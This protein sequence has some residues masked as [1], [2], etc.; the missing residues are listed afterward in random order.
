M[1][2]A[3]AREGGLPAS[4]TFAEVH[5]ALEMPLNALYLT[6]SI[7]VMFGFVFL[8]STTAFNAIAVASFVALALS[9][10]MPL[11]VHCAQGRNK[12]PK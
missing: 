8:I 12:L 2:Y 6:T 1:V 4:K 10:A 3:F 9:Y 7:T 5:P 11:A